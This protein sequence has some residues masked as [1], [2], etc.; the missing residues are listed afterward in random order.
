MDNINVYGPTSDVTV[1]GFGNSELEDILQKQADL[2]NR[3]IR[4]EPEPEKGRFYR[5]DHFNFAK[6]GVPMIYPKAGI[7]HTSLGPEH[8]AQQNK[9]YTAQRY[10][11][12]EDEI[13]DSWDLAG[14]V[15]DLQLYFRFGLEISNGDHWPKWREG[16]EF[17]AIR[18]SSLRENNVTH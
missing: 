4:A 2:T 7:N 3:V 16:N 14:L 17:K 9:D 10:H 1:V 15:E 12:P 18:E 6:H 11:T 5:S 13:L 8:M